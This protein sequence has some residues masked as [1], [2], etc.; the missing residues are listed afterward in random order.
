MEAEEE[1]FYLE[2][3]EGKS[4]E[5][6]EGERTRGDGWSEGRTRERRATCESGLCRRS[7]CGS[8][9]AAYGGIELSREAA[10]LLTDE[11]DNFALVL[12]DKEDIA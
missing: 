6:G 10:E 9:A 2:K 7:S 4:A 11:E 12:L 1:A 5:N 3:E 8:R